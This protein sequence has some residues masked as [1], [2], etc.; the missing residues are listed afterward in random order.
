MPGEAPMCKCIEAIR[1]HILVLKLFVRHTHPYNKALVLVNL[2]VV[3]SFV[4]GLVFLLPKADENSIQAGLTIIAET[5]GVL[6][7]VTFVVIVLL[8]EQGRQAEDVLIVASQKYRDLLTKHVDEIDTERKE[9]VTS[10]KRGRIQ[11]DEPQPGFNPVEHREIIYSL[12]QLV[13]VLRSELL[14]DVLRDLY[15]L[16]YTQE[17]TKDM[18]IA[19]L[20]TDRYPAEFLQFVRT[21]LNQRFIPLWKSN[22]VRDLVFRVNA[23]Y[24]RD[25]I[26]TALRRLEKLNSVLKSKAFAASIA[27][28][29]LT[30]VLAVLTVFGVTDKTIY[31]SLYQWLII[32]SMAGFALSVVLALLLVKKMLV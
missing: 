32:V 26:R 21:T 23:Q 31:A 30:T 2:L 4:F 19:K 29:T 11:L 13:I 16:G 9:L 1:E 7:G 10:V 22:V 14:G 12:S 6:I 24:S 5:L 20:R 15:D 8:I 27:V 25:G 28:P 3:V 18:P 17:D